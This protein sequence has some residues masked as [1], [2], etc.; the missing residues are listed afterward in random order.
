MCHGNGF[1]LTQEP[2]SEGLEEE[3]IRYIGFSQEVDEDI[4]T[5]MIRKAASHFASWQREQMMRNAIERKVKVDAG[6]YPYIDA[7]E[8]YDYDK[9]EPLAKGGDEI[10]LIII[11]ED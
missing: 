5:A 9:D 2:V 1:F 6:G 4:G 3:I 10:K 11:K 7:M 8:L